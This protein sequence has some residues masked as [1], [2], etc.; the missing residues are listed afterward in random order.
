M[1]GFS[2]TACKTKVRNNDNSTKTT[3][4]QDSSIRSIKKAYKEMNVVKEIIF[5]SPNDT[6][7][8]IIQSSNIRFIIHYFNNK[9]QGILIQP[10]QEQDS[11]VSHFVRDNRGVFISISPKSNAISFVGYKYLRNDEGAD[12]SIG[13]GGNTEQFTTWGEYGSE[14]KTYDIKQVDAGKIK[15]YVIRDGEKTDSLLYLRK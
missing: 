5:N 3:L 4:Y 2:F 12:I 15:V 11:L 6:G 9:P 8:V 7:S 14:G 10:N 13:N 1:M